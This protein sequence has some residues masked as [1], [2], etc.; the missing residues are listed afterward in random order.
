MAIPWEKEIRLGYLSIFLGIS[1][2]YWVNYLCSIMN[3]DPAGCEGVGIELGATRGIGF[4]SVI[5]LCILSD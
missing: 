3:S 2:G 4:V 1:Y 5:Q